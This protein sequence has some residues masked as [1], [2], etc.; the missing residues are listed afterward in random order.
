MYYIPKIL[1]VI[2]HVEI[3]GQKV[4]SAVNEIF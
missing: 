3:S 1:V 4:V 2:I